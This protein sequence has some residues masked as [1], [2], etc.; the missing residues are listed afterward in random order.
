[1][2]KFTSLIGGLGLGAGLMFILDPDRGRGRRAVI[3]DKAKSALRE[4]ED[5]LATATRDLGNRTGGL[6]VEAG[7]RLTQSPVSDATLLARVRSKLGRATAHPRAIDVIVEGGRVILRGPVL[8]SEVASIVSVISKVSGVREVEN[9]LEVHETA[10]IAE[11]QGPSGIADEK[12][13][14]LQRNWSPATRLLAG[15]AGSLLA[16]FGARKGGVLGTTLGTVGLGLLTRGVTNTGLTDLVGLS[17]IQEGLQNGDELGA[18]ADAPNANSGVKSGTSKGANAGAGASASTTR[19]ANAGADATAGTNRGANADAGASAGTNRGANADAAAT[20]S[21]N[22]GANA[23]ANDGANKGAS[24]GANKGA[25]AGA[26]TNANPNT[27]ARANAEIHAA[28]GVASSG[29]SGGNRGGGN[30]GGS[31]SDGVA[32]QQGSNAK[33]GAPTGGSAGNSAGT[34]GTGSGTQR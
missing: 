3:R 21:T 25:N 22:R 27:G 10:D 9:L 1:M 26:G 33:S 13:D 32:A 30:R 6:L 5:A 31:Q 34:R 18:N 4:T 14:I 23:D 15:T 11:L 29:R 24:A 19:K 20:T 28:D 17:G 2:N 12:L 7:S 8:A 16:I